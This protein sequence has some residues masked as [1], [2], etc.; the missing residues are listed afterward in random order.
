MIL[1]VG[2]SVGE[3]GGDG[4]VA[5]GVGAEEIG[6]AGEGFAGLAVDE[7]ANLFDLGEVGVEGSDD[8]L[9]G[10]GFDFDA[11]GMGVGEGGAEVDDGELA[12][13]S[14]GLRVVGVRGGYGDGGGEVA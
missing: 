14:D 4:G 3:L 5:G 12:A 9:E 2:G 13:G 11:G 8:G 6:V 10:E 7:E 1:G